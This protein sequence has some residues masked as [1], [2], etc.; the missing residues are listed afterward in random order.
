VEEVVF[1][2]P[3]PERLQYRCR[4]TSKESRLMRFLSSSH[5]ASGQK[6]MAEKLMGFL[7]AQMD[8]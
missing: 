6:P 1:P 3:R 2:E 5:P 4:F 7:G 8:G